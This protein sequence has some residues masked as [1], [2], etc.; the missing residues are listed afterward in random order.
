[1]CAC[2]H[3]CIC[4]CV[5]MC[6]YACVNVCMYIY[7][8]VDV[9]ISIC[10]HVLYKHV[11]MCACV[12]VGIRSTCICMQRSGVEVECLSLLVSSLFLFFK[13]ACL[14]LGVRVL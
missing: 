1:M 7:V 13:F 3:M 10:M 9:C 11:F 2:V 5:D 4:E 12:H 14:C 6:I 8:C